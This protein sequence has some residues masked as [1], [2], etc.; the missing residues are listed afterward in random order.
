MPEDSERVLAV[1]EAAHH[2][3]MEGLAGRSIQESDSD[4][5]VREQS[6]QE[7]RDESRR[8]VYPEFS[9]SYFQDLQ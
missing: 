8:A 3:V 6:N 9:S 7:T 5:E 2:I 1:G 4:K